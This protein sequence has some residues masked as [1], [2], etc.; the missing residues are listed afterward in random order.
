MCSGQLKIQRQILLVVSWSINDIFRNRAE[1]IFVVGEIAH[2]F[3]WKV[4]KRGNGEGGGLIFCKSPTKPMQL[5]L[6]ELLSELWLS[7][8][9]SCNAETS[10][11]TWADASVTWRSMQ[12]TWVTIDTKQVFYE[13][14]TITWVCLETW[15]KLFL[16]HDDFHTK[17]S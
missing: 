14:S 1:H 13:E 10:T 12:P 11:L 8:I 17:R 9:Q 4:E 2:Y 5:I 6:W 16:V 15:V 3:G 7:A